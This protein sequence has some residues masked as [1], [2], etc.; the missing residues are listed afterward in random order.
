MEVPK[1]AHT[2]THA[3]M[4]KG[5]RAG[6]THTYWNCS[7]CHWC[8]M[9]RPLQSNQ[10]DPFQKGHGWK[11]QGQPSCDPALLTQG[12][13]APASQKTHGPA[14]AGTSLCCMCRAASLTL[15]WETKD[16]QGD[17]WL[18]WGRQGCQEGAA[19]QAWADVQVLGFPGRGSEDGVRGE[20]GA[21]RRDGCS[22]HMGGRGGHGSIPA[23][24]WGT[25]PLGM[26]VRLT[27]TRQ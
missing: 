15:R 9:S 14:P 8:L 17:A 19:W 27:E 13:V 11:A 4:H 21:G 26:G 2:Y 20:E 10:R 23:L 12:R 5:G 18:L 6:E 22:M 7:R 25:L 3:H 1:H 16:V 24:G